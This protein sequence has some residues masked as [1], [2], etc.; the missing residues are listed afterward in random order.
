MTQLISSNTV[1]AYAH[2]TRPLCDGAS[3]QPVQALREETGVTYAEQGGD[4]GFVDKSFVTL[5]FDDDDDA[6]CPHCGRPRELTEQARVQYQNLSGVDP[7]G[8]VG[9]KYGAQTRNSPLNGGPDD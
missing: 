6:A 7:D 1:T 3:Q 9:I 2:C 5:R 4:L 8:L